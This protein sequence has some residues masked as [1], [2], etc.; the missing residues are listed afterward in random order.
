MLSKRAMRYLRKWPDY[1]RFMTK[2]KVKGFRCWAGE[3]IYNIDTDG[4]IAACDIMTHVKQDNPSCVELGLKKAI[5]K[6]SKDG[7]KACTCA[8]VIE[9]NYMFSFRPDVIF[10]W[11]KLVYTK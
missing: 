4:K 5:R 11:S 6:V 9:Y 2:K 1:K 3:L 10:D 8:H 7:C